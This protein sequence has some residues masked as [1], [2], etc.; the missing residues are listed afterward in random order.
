MDTH[1][2]S[3][4]TNWT[5]LQ[6]TA[7]TSFATLCFKGWRDWRDWP[8]I[9]SNRDASNR[10][11]IDIVAGTKT[12]CPTEASELEEVQAT[13]RQRSLHIQSNSIL[14]EWKRVEGWDSPNLRL[15]FFTHWPHWLQLSPVSRQSLKAPP[16]HVSARIP[17][18]F[19]LAAD[20][21]RSQGAGDGAA[22]AG[23]C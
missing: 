23:S 14:S 19:R 12:A 10:P 4:Q 13:L 11:S 18:C 15:S 7:A 22:A 1:F 17:P 9:K 6:C 5:T 2:M 16:C 21:Q 20:C 8:A 3:L